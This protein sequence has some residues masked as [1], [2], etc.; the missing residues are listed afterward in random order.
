MKNREAI[1]N[2]IQA[3]LGRIYHNATLRGSLRTE[4]DFEEDIFNEV[5]ESERNMAIEDAETEFSELVDMFGHIYQFGRGGRT[6][7]FDDLMKGHGG[8]RYSVKTLEELG[9]DEIDTDKLERILILLNRFNDEVRSWCKSAPD[10]ILRDIREE[11]A[12]EIKENRNKKRTTVT[13]YR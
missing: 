2:G 5:F 1:L 12:E 10:H 11:Y 6:L 13:V 8:S 7:A 3:E 9:L 4:S